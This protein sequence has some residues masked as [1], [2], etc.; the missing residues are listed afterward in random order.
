MPCTCVCWCIIIIIIIIIISS[1]GWIFTVGGARCPGCGLACT[2]K[3]AT[4]GRLL[5]GQ[6]VRG[7]FCKRIG[8][9][10]IGAVLTKLQ[11]IAAM[12]LLLL[13]LLQWRG[14][15]LLTA[16]GTPQSSCTAASIP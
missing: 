16:A 7:C 4:A 2:S 9:N 5:R 12:L 3:P 11:R 15:A 6:H 14:T 10:S 1:N 13:L 8:A